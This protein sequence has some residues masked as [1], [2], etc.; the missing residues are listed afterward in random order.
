MSSVHIMHPLSN[1][2]VSSQFNIQCEGKI[3]YQD[4]CI[5]QNF[6]FPHFH[7]QIKVGCK[8]VTKDLKET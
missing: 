3:I 4:Y 1:Q 5:Y 8:P 6:L 2:D 7:P